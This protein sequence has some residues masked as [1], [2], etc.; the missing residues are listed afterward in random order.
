MRS[1]RSRGPWAQNLW[2][3][4]TRLWSPYSANESLDSTDEFSLSTVSL[5]DICHLKNSD[6][7]L[8]FN[9]TKAELRSEVT[10]QKMIQALMQHSLN[11]DHQ[12]H[13]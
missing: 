13:R 11:K 1:R 10:L 8:N 6:L 5:M 12:H 2:R 3:G 9:N 7:E 4:R